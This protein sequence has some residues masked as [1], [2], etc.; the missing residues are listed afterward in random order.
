M[1]RRPTTADAFNAVAEASRRE[2]LDALGTGEAT[3]GELVDRLRM[4]QPQVSK[5]LAVLRAVGLVLVRVEGRH[6]WYRV[7]GPALKPIHDWVRTFERTW[8]TRLDRLDDL[9]AELQSRE[10]EP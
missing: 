7:N 6:H 1:A 3:V 2:L 8:N 9:L 10:K 4:S 5:H